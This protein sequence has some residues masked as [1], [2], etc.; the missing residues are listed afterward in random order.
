M[1]I[2]DDQ[3]KQYQREGDVVTDGLESSVK[4]EWVTSH[5]RV[6]MEPV[7]ILFQQ[8]LVPYATG[9]RFPGCV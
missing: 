7:G 5:I 6:P 4:V 3:F 8:S 2:T 1:K 9:D